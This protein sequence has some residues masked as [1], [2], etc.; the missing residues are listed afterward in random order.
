MSGAFD[1][2]MDRSANMKITAIP[3][4]YR[5]VN[6]SWE[7]FSVLSKYGLADWLSRFDFEFAKTLFRNRS[8][9]GLGSLTRETRIRLALAE[10]G[11]TFIKLGQILST[12]A[13]L[14]GVRLAEELEQ[15][16][17]AVEHDPPATVRTTI[18][19]ELRRPVDDLFREFDDTPLASASIGQVH[20]ARLLSGQAV[21]VKVQHAGIEERVRIDL[22]ILAGL[23][24]LAQRVP[25]FANYRPRAIVAEFQRTLR[26]ELDFSRERRNIERF[27]RDLASRSEVR[28]PATY[29]S[30]STPRVLTMEYLDG[31]KFSD[32]AR[33]SRHDFDMDLIARRGADLFLEMIFANGFYHADPHP[34]NLILMENNTIGL[35]DFGMVGRIDE[36]L[37]ESIEDLLLAIIAQDPEQLTAIIMRLGA[38]PVGLDDVALGLEVADF[39]AH[40]GHV[41]LGDLNLS[42]ALNE[43]T[44]IIRRYQIMLPARLA[45]L[46]KV[47]VMLEGTGRLASK[48]FNLMEVLAPYRRRMLLR[49]LSPVRRAKKFRRIYLEMERLVE[50]LPRRL[51]DILQQVQSGE[52]DVHLDHRGLEPSV[53]RLVLGMLAS[54]LFLGSSLLVSRNVPPLFHEV[55]II[56]ATG[57]VLSIVWG[58]RLLRAINKS[59]HLDRHKSQDP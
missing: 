10:L 5:H 13:D 47:L 40:Y 57:M 27:A 50:I 6:R 4:L 17:T 19:R 20:R 38:V 39:V 9:E 44:E 55:S 14:I 24:V 2:P 7:I 29:P 15:L 21:A 33:D 49:R 46:L 22:E 32:A 54:A 37:R 30:L 11:P 23:A 59:G 1:P 8:G 43:M 51:G 52:F 41:S 48:N 35:V 25:E 36:L 3:Q 28:I 34:G 26:R 18:A 16:Q 42:S 45:L 58:L 31:V 53:N 56:G 12:R